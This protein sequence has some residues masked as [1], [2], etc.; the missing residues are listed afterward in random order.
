MGKANP[1]SDIRRVVIPGVIFHSMISH[2]SEC[3]P[4]EACGILAGK[5][6]LV[7]EIFRM[8]NIDPSPARYLMEPAEQ[9]RV[10]TELRSRTL[11]MVGIYHSHPS[12]LAYPSSR[13]MEL[14][15][16]EEAIYIIVSL[17]GDEPVVKGFAIKDGASREIEIVKI[18]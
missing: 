1:E 6:S 18:L 2:C 4:N 5:D 16:Y 12:A 7:S 17:A 14:A 8:T 15:F 9:F 11:S 3:R 10:M 13:D